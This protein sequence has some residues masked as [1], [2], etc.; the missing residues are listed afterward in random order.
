MP[1]LNKDFLNRVNSTQSLNMKY[2]YAKGNTASPAEFLRTTTDELSVEESPEKAL[3]SA[4]V[5]SQYITANR[6]DPEDELLKDAKGEDL[7]FYVEMADRLIDKAMTP[8]QK[9]ALFDAMSKHNLA[10]IESLDEEGN[11]NLTKAAEERIAEERKEQ[12]IENLNS[13]K[14]AAE[15]NAE[16]RKQE[17]ERKALEQKAR[18]NVDKK[19]KDAFAKAKEAY[20]AQDENEDLTKPNEILFDTRFLKSLNPSD[21]AGKFLPSEFIPKEQR[22]SPADM[23]ARIRRDNDEK[24]E[25]SVNFY[26]DKQRTIAQN[27]FGCYFGLRSKLEN[28]SFL[29]FLKHPIDSIRERIQMYGAKNDI[30]KNYGLNDTAIDTMYDLVMKTPVDINSI[31][32]EYAESRLP[33]GFGYLTPD[34]KIVRQ[35]AP[36]EEYQ[37]ELEKLEKESANAKENAKIVNEM[38]ER[39]L[40]PETQEELWQKNLETFKNDPNVT[41]NGLRQNATSPTFHNDLNK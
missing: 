2:F 20:E 19:Y 38:K 18:E 13:Q 28:E 11:V 10:D 6:N 30:Q 5:I 33:E 12:E 31:I 39:G 27:R 15:K 24:N 26:N 1:N 29:D 21:I 3:M 41:V 23:A 4:I 36:E 7:D 25:R 9:K 16:D 40:D 32:P 37:K 34:G 17:E 22:V 8:A 35:T 14:A